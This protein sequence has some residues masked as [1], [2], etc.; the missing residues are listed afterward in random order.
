MNLFDA[1]AHAFSTVSTGGFSPYDA[2]LAHF[3]S[4][5]IEAVATVFMFLG[6]VSFALHFT[7]DRGAR[8]PARTGAT[9]SS[10]PISC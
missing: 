2:S 6:G 5:A 1:V 10:R 4:P 7:R 9:P 3:N 8:L